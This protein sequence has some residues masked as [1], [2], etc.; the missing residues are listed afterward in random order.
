M[1][2][3]AAEHKKYLNR[4]RFPETID[5]VSREQLL[6]KQQET[7]RLQSLE[8]DNAIRKYEVGHE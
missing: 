7:E 1:K 6:Q 4:Q 5:E 3:S 2:P 8:T